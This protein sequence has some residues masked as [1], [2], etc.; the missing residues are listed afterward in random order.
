ME[1]ITIDDLAKIEIKIGQ[2]LKVER[3]EGSEKLLKLAVDFGGENPRIVLSGIAKFFEN[4]TDLE[5]RK[6][7]FVTNLV[8]REIMGMKSQAMILAVSGQ[9]D[10]GKFFSTLN[11]DFSV[12]KGASVK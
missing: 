5:G 3:I 1:K 6:C 9:N 4:I 8:E 7:A 10:D 11:T 2:V 12:P